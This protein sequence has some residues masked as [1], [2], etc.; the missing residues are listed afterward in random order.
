MTSSSSNWIGNLSATPES[1]KPV[2]VVDDAE[3]ILK[4]PSINEDQDAAFLH[5]VLTLN[6]NAAVK[7][8]V[9]HEEMVNVL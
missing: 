5:V 9:C 4:V 7:Q 6:T 8:L 2:E 3:R 1:P